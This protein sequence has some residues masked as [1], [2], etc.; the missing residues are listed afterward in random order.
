MKKILITG[1]SDGLGKEIAKQ[2]DEKGYDLFLFGRN[3]EKLD[4]LDLKHVVKK[5]A[6]DYTNRNEL[7]AALKD[8]NSLGGVD[9]LINNAGANPAKA[10]VLDIKIE[11]FEYMMNLNCTGHLICIQELAPSM[12]NNGGGQI[13]NVLSSSCL[14]NNPNVASYTASK[15]AMEAISKILV[16][17]VKDKNIKVCDIYPGGINTNFRALDRPDYLNPKTIAKQVVYVI[18]NNDD[19][20]IQEIVTRPIVE[21]NY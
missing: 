5:Y 21:N 3:K 20:M 11:D 18:E 9:V 1:A 14:F 16:K 8:I 4:S 15:K 12:I 6:F 7:Y 19:G 2:L 13:I 10:N 17:E